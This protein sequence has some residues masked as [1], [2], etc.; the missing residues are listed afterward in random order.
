[1]KKN[2]YS[3]ISIGVALVAFFVINSSIIPAKTT[4]AAAALADGITIEEEYVIPD[5]C[6]LSTYYVIVAKNNTGADVAVDADFFAKDSSGNV[7]RKVNDYS[8]A[9]GKDQT[10]ILYGQ[11][12]NSKIE[13]AKDYEYSLSVKETDRCAYAS[14]DI[15]SENEDDCINVSAH[16]KSDFDVNG[17]GVRTVFMKDGKAVGFD[18]VNIADVGT[19]FKGGSTNSQQV[20]MNTSDYDD[21]ILTYTSYSDIALGDL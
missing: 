10:F 11:F 14:I 12:T 17:V 8:E 21:Y 2:I 18:T 6:G 19:T 20:G 16:N 7:V 9:V 1:M 5:A 13:N 3:V 4:Y 15:D